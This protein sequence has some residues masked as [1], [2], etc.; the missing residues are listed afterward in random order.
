MK[1]LHEKYVNELTDLQD[2]EGKDISEA[3]LSIFGS[4]AKASS[5]NVKRFLAMIR[6]SK[7]K[8]IRD[9]VKMVKESQMKAKELG[10]EFGMVKLD[11]ITSTTGE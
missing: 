7:K 9:A 2:K 3:F 6:L 10:K 1:D 5:G 11:A 8:L 4:M